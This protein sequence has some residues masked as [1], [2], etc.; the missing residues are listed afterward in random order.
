MIAYFSGNFKF[1]LMA[2]HDFLK[3]QE[4][5]DLLSYVRNSFGNKASVV[6]VGEVKAERAQ[7]KK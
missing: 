5:A 4:I 7:L 6:S 1:S 2:P 3:D